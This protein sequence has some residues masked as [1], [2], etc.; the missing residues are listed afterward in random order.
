VGVAYSFTP[1]ATNA[2]SFTYSGTLPPGISFSS[3]T[4]AL[5]AFPTTA[6][7]YSNIVITAANSTGAASLTPF[8]I[9]VNPPTGDMN[10]D[11]Q[12]T[13]ADALLAL[14]TVVG[15]Y[16]ATPQ[17]ILRA[18]VAPL[19]NGEPDPTGS[20]VTIADALLILQKVVGSV[21]W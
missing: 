20:S 3:T 4:G 13:I 12:V 5:S 1:T 6:G 9:T 17:Q 2:S 14:Q 10:G 15:L 8:N 7:L 21:T 16:V 18:N 11:G 19:V